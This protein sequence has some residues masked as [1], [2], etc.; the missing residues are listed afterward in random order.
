MKQVQSLSDE[1]MFRESWS[2]ANES[3][4]HKGPEPLRPDEPFSIEEW[5]LQIVELRAAVSEL[6]EVL[7]GQVD[8]FD[9]HLEMSRSEFKNVKPIIQGLWVAMADLRD[10]AREMHLA[11]Y[12]N[13][14]VGG[15]FASNSG[16]RIGNA[17]LVVPGLNVSALAST[18]DVKDLSQPWMGL[19]SVL[20][21][22]KGLLAN[23]DV[24]FDEI[25]DRRLPG[26]GQ[27]GEPQHV[28]LPHDD[29]SDVPCA[30]ATMPGRR[31]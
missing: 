17:L 28:A 7:R 26:T 18:R 8:D 10:I 27:T 12:E 4:A 5:E 1:A 2:P 9:E 3:L 30:R 22:S 14:N 13:S 21:G 15:G 24:V 23:Y 25:G 31:R 20:H 19:T 29:S 6:T 11:L 16:D